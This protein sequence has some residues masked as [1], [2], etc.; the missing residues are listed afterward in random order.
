MHFA[1]PLFLA[2]LLTLT[3]AG[4]IYSPLASG[5][6][7]PAIAKYLSNAAFGSGLLKA[8]A[9][10]C[11]SI[12]TITMDAGALPPPADGLK[13]WHIAIGR[14]TQNYT[15]PVEKGESAAPVPL[16]AVATLYNATCIAGR[17]GVDKVRDMTNAIAL[18]DRDANFGLQLLQSGNHYFPDTA[19]TV[20]TFNLNMGRE[21]TNYGI[22]FQKKTSNVTAP[23]DAGKG[24]DGSAAV[25]W[26]QLTAP[27]TIPNG[28][29]LRAQDA[30]SKIVNVYRLNTAGGAGP[31]TCQGLL[32]QSFTRE[33]AAEYWFWHR[34]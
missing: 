20:A 28:Y 7:P 5:S 8:I 6:F 15:C 14:G 26:L 24:Q 19:A 25:P 3:S 27:E 29:T 32:G 1:T 31:K 17:A 10:M 30:S 33:Y 23:A 2:S 22:T 12:D 9:P 18:Q 21:D 4:P 11:S 16:G 13:L 34:V